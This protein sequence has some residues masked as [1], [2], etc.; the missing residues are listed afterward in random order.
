MLFLPAWATF[1]TTIGLV[2][3]SPVSQDATMAK[4]VASDDFYEPPSGFEKA[5]L[6]DVL[7]TRPIVASFFTYVP[8]LTEAV[9]LLYRTEDL[10]GNPIVAA[11]TVFKPLLSKGDR[12]VSFQTAYD[13]SA[14]KCSPSLTYQFGNTSNNII[15]QLEF[16]LLQV[17]LLSGYIVSSPDYE[18]PEAPFSVGRLEAKGVL[19]SMRA[20]RNYSLQ[21]GLSTKSPSIVGVG[22]SGGGI[23]TGWAAA[24][25]T[26]YA[27]DLNLKGWVMGGVPANLEATIRHIDNTVYSGF[28][29]VSLAGLLKPTAFGNI[30]QPFVDSITTPAAKAV[31]AETKNKCGLDMVIA[32]P[33]KS[34]LSRDF[35]SM[36]SEFLSAPIMAKVLNQS[37]IGILHSEK[38][39]VPIKQYHATKDLVVPYQ[40]ALDLHDEWCKQGVVSHF[41]E[42]AAGGHI[43]TEVLAIADALRFVSDVFDGNIIRSCSKKVVLDNSLDPLA[44][45]LNL[46]PILVA[47]AITLANRL[48]GE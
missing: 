20:V 27:P 15:T 2:A 44:L 11:T 34:I 1:A 40:P 36:G 32:W 42:Y 5:A 13:S 28:I 25:Q 48:A 22:Y 29:P 41:V 26:S 17:Y 6:G 39:S 8:A 37:I 33:K 35:Q 14:F 43:S 45:G 46:E 38:P 23:A 31:L 10:N 4:V 18:G 47:L 24:L 9:Q 12:F 3:A 19:D 21:L 16:L 7:R 30:L